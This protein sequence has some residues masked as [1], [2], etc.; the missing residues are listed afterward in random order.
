MPQ[1]RGPCCNSRCCSC[2]EDR[3]QIRIDEADCMYNIE[4]PNLR[5][6]GNVRV[7]KTD[8]FDFRPVQ[9]ESA[10]CRCPVGLKTE[11]RGLPWRAS[12]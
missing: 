7:H 8:N 3:R 4:L 9:F 10:K 5:G 11:F 6:E 1:L 12:G 2:K